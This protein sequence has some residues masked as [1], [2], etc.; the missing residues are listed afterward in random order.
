VSKYPHRVSIN[1][2]QVSINRMLGVYGMPM[3]QAARDAPASRNALL[4]AAGLSAAYGNYT[5]HVLPLL[6]AGLLE[7]THPENPRHRTQRYRLT[8]LGR[9]TLLGQEDSQ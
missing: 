5:R 8:K 7:F 6:G 9:R 4:E 3:L 2:H 1:E